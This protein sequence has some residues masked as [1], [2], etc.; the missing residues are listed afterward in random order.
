MTD[1]NDVLRIELQHYQDKFIFS[2]NRYPAI[3]GGVGTGKTSSSTLK[4][5]LYIVKI[6]LML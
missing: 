6:I 1:N 3:I 5:Y 4:A 2:K